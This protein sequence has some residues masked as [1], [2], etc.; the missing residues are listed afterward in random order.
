LPQRTGAV[1]AFSRDG[2]RLVTGGGD[3]TITIWP[4]PEKK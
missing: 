2:K 1:L 3:G 4:V